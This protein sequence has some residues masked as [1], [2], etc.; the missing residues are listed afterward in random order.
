MPSGVYKRTPEMC[1]NISASHKGMKAWNKGLTGCMSDEGR[2]RMIKANTGNKYHLGFKH[3]DEAKRKMSIANLGKKR[4]E[5]GFLNRIVHRGEDHYNWKGGVSSIDNGKY[6]SLD[7]I[8]IRSEIYKRDRWICQECGVKC[9]GGYRKNKIQCHHIDYN[10]ENCCPDNLITLCVS[11]HMKTNYNRED[12]IIRYRKVALKNNISFTTMK[13][14][15]V[16][17][18]NAS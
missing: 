14:V 2:A 17:D 6:N 12:W 16:N 4:T 3:N 5:P 13:K 9:Q 7:W 15:L 10:T 1:A 8:K 18:R 11:C